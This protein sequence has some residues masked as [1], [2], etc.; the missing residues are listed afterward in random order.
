MAIDLRPEKYLIDKSR[1]RVNGVL[2]TIGSGGTVP[3][4]F[5]K[6]LDE[7]ASSQTGGR[8][9]FVAKAKQDMRSAMKS[10]QGR[11][12]VLTHNSSLMFVDSASALRNAL[13]ASRWSVPETKLAE[14]FPSLF[15]KR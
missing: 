11:I 6:M 8:R 5:Q 13:R 9:E 14:A 15:K 2:V 12:L 1:R 7:I 3:G 10:M 4:R